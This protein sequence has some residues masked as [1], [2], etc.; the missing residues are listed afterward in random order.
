M[1]GKSEATNGHAR[2]Y[3]RIRLDQ[4]QISPSNV[5]QRD[6]TA[7]LDKLAYSMRT[8]GLQH[9]IIVQRKGDK[10]EI[11]VGQR[12]YLAAKQLGWDA[13]DAIIEKEE[14]DEFEAK[15][16]S[17]SENVQRRDLAPRD[18]ADACAYLLKKL[19]S[20]RAVSEHLGIGE[21]TVRRWLG[22]A[23]VPEK[24]KALVEEGKVSRPVATR[25]AEHVHDERQ[26]VAI[27]E[28]IAEMKPAKEHQDRILEAV[29]ESPDRSVD[30]IL[31]RAEETRVRK[32]ITFVLPE[33]WATAMDRASKQ[34]ARDVNEI[35]RDATIEWL[36]VRSY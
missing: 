24:L 16:L 29:E 28:K 4:L 30:V 10:F 31:R 3:G 27:A 26:A 33:K 35:A 8:L 1:T 13:I 22:Y 21:Q 17:F 25:I 34:L 9:P 18:K 11:L 12:R 20:P 32:E 19:G 15:V 7:D 23:A 6:I 5:R 36:E 14:R 2:E